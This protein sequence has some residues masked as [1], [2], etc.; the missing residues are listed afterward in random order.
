MPMLRVRCVLCK[1]L[2]ATGL[3]VDYETFKDLTYTDRVLECP[4]C[5]KVQTWNL[6]DVDR[7]VFAK[8][9]NK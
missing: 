3:N 2:V 5:E 7:S 4:R 1:E 8:T 9:S 6:D